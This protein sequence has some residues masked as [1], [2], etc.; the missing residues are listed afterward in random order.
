MPAGP[1]IGLT[2]AGVGTSHSCRRVHGLARLVDARRGYSELSAFPDFSPP[3]PLA[4]LLF[5]LVLLLAYLAALPAL[6]P[7]ERKA[8]VAEAVAAAALGLI[9]LGFLLL[10]MRWA[11]LPAHL[12]T[13]LLALAAMLTMVRRRRV[14][15]PR[16]EDP[17]KLS[18][19]AVAATVAFL[20]PCVIGGWLMG[21]G[22][23]PKLFFHAGTAFRL[24]H[25]HQFIDDR[26]MPPLSLS[27]LGI[28]L[29]YHYAAPAAASAVS[30]ITGLTAA[31]SFMLT[32]TA[33][34]A[35]VVAASALLADCLRGGLSFAIRFAVIL[36]AAPLTVWSAG[37]AASDWISDP[38]LF[39]NHFPDVSVYFGI[40]LFLLTLYGCLDLANRRRL[41]LAL[42][43]TIL[44][45]GVKSSYF[46]TAGLLVFSGAL[47]RTYATRDL[48]W[49]LL[50][51]AAFVGGFTI[52]QTTGHPITGSLAIEP[53]FLFANFGKKS[54]KYLLDVVLFL[55]PVVAYLWVSGGWRKL[56][57][58][59]GQR[60]LILGL[61]LVGLFVFLNLFGRHMTY[62]DGD[63]GPDTNILV[64]LRVMPKLLAVATVLALAV[65]W[66]RT[67]SKLNAA[68]LVYLVLL[69]LLPLSHKATQAL[70]YIVRPELGHEYVDNR[71]IAEA[72]AKIPVK[73]S[74]IATNDLRYP[75]NDFRRDQRQMQIPA[76]FGHQAFAANTSFEPY[77]EAAERVALQM[78]LQ[79][80]LWDPSIL[81]AARKAG[82]THILIHKLAPYPQ[83]IP[84]NKIF[85]NER[86]A[87]YAI[88]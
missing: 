40:F 6:A 34:T 81:P 75:A 49:M 8:N 86:Y 64:P 74:V 52:M 18:L 87:V 82:W 46:P 38:Q 47:V 27:N 2:F 23:Y 20:L 35:G 3:W 16:L 12:A 65:L 9:C 48:R 85:E 13:A 73:G 79:A 58:E 24:V 50:P 77:P 31:A 71:P 60:L 10:V 29:G 41:V 43:A 4:L 55:L 53:F 21:I 44:I 1:L 19:L 88:E 11:S 25:T 37:R 7:G 70:I 61:A 28:R 45:A 59:A 62:P 84:L 32:L 83:D 78:R 72:L 15:L 33:G 51:V 69:F 26:G 30:L 67:R 66:D 22:D 63:Y 56:S 68:V 17:S 5:G 36:G 57:A 54:L 80:P 76:I 42:L 14:L 39:F